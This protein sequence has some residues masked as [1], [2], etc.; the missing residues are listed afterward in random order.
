VAVALVNP[1]DQGVPVC[2]SQAIFGVDCPFCGGLRCTNALLRGHLGEALDH[3]VVLAA[4][5]PVMGLLW[6]WWV[7][8]QWRGVTDPAPRVPR[9]LTVTAAV[10]LVAFTVVRNL[11]G[12]A[13]ARWLHSDIYRG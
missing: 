2:W 10:L 13:W 4:A 11:G 6:V 1:G 3:N 9:W 7:A 12:P 5:L 8:R